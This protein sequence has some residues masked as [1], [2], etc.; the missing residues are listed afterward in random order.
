MLLFFINIILAHP[1]RG[2]PPLKGWV[3]QKQDGADCE[4]RPQPPKSQALRP[5]FTYLK[6][7]SYLC[8]PLCLW[9][10]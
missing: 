3:F 4:A 7:L 10:T 2:D 1:L 5:G 8:G 9:P 6:F